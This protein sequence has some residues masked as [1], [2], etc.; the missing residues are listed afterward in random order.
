VDSPS[1]E[2]A[3]PEGSP[4]VGI[5]VVSHSARLAEGVVEL[6]RQV[7]GP[8]VAIV[9]AG[10]LDQPDHPLG[11]D[12]ALVVRSVAAAWSEAG[13]LVLMDLGSAV[14][15]A[16][17]A[18]ELLGEERRSR[19]LLCPA[20]LVEG[21]VAA[22]V[23]ARLG[24][25][26]E[27]VASEAMAGLTGKQAQLSPGP[28]QTAGAA[29][30]ERSGALQETGEFASSEG[31]EP[32]P[33][34]GSVADGVELSITEPLGLHAR[35]AARLVETVGN[36]DAT[37]TLE[38]LTSGKGPVPA[39][40]LSMVAT[41]GVRQ[42]DRV[43][44]RASGP[45][46]AQAL[47]AVVDLAAAG[48][49]EPSAPRPTESAPVA[50]DTRPLATSAGLTIAPG[51][52]LRGFGVSPG[53][54]SGPARHLQSAAAGL[55]RDALPGLAASQS[56]KSALT[57][58][59]TGHGFDPEVEWARLQA[60]IESTAL[61]VASERKRVLAAGASDEAQIFDAHLLLLR[62]EALLGPARSMVDQGRS[63]LDAWESSVATMAER[64]RELSDAYQRERVHDLES[65]GAQVS[66]HLRGERRAA[67]LEP[68]IVVVAE[69]T[70][71]EVAGF[72]PAVVSG[73][74]AAFG[75]PTSHGAILVRALGIPAAVGLGEQLLS[76]P[77]GT[78]LLLD[79]SAGTVCIDP[80]PSEHGSA[81]ERAQHRP[82]GDDRARRM[83][84]EPA[85]TIDG[86]R[87]EVAA[88]AG[89]I[90]DA[91][92]A[93]AIGADGIGL[94]RTEF[95]FMDAEAM[96]TE[97]Q[98]EA[99][100]RRIAETLAGRPVVVRTLDVGADKP[101]PYL[102]R[103]PEANPQLGQRGLR[104]GL[105]RPDLLLAQLRAVLRVAADHPL[106][107]MFPMVATEAEVASAMELV[108]QAR[109]E[110]H[111]EGVAVPDKGSMQVG[112]MIEV[113]AAA[114]GARTLA[115]SVDFFSVGTNDLTQYTFAVDRDLASVAS[116]ADAM[117]PAV[118][119]LI[120][121]AA[122][123]ALAAGRWI[124]VCGEL[125]ADPAAVPVLIGLGVRELSVSPPSV[126]AVKQAVRE[127][128][129][130][131]C[132]EL[133]AR[134]LELPSAAAVRAEVAR[135]RSRTG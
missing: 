76:V 61:D 96:P 6:A 121:L 16:E 97:A 22:A 132:A 5:V 21:A 30:S 122:R 58:S 87:I 7:A 119:R 52:V 123:A 117:H 107:L 44:V 27:K 125:A 64:W 53:I 33:G 13:V 2:T 84:A 11:T 105:A 20:P 35:P 72:D 108:E 25:P 47:Q 73:V 3:P 70:P 46:A 26:L 127:A 116:L 93:A 59:P 51:E 71:A 41:L 86:T 45:Q 68:G 100:Y 135:N 17:T 120:D 67:V 113:P 109:S 55:S 43:L 130:T 18:L 129:V 28:E 85:V 102:S 99:V 8:G 9:A 131:S 32:S 65:I 23:A 133:A 106:K 62:D 79:G 83:A 54:A 66:A 112:V 95:I 60:A 24:A 10:G 110:L 4:L 88:N 90:E 115:K 89:S 77:E 118:L 124:G 126:A 114:L 80:S 101:L 49:G 82:D 40:S 1:T 81:V 36:F 111:S 128:D 98:Q 134:V 42:G 14:L 37:V 69:L 78:P 12:A 74:G 38:N 34:E 19:V 91:E 63:A 56:S 31:P 103:P 15:S 92:R 39:N 57:D 104:L 75:G 94:L 29:E 48:F 50:S